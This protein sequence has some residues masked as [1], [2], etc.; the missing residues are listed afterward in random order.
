[1]RVMASIRGEEETRPY[2][3]QTFRFRENCGLYVIVGYTENAELN[4]FETLADHLSFTGIGGKRAAGMGK[5]TLYTGK[6]PTDL[7]KRLK[8]SGNRYMILSGSLPRE[9]ELEACL[10]NAEYLLS[11]RSGFVSSDTYSSEYMRKR[12]LYVLKAG[13]CVC[14]KYEGD[15]YDVSGHAGKHPVYRYAK[16]MFVEVD[17]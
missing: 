11:K 1:M 7:N 4:L 9:E 2:R 10:V 5:F 17:A 14:R 15:V 16:P 6:M 13:S 3:V 12:D 8:S